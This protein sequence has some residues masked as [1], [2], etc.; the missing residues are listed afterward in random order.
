[1]TPSDVTLTAM[2]AAEN[3]QDIYGPFDSDS[4]LMDALDA[5]ASLISSFLF[6]FQT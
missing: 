6:Y 4:S 3:S 2:E 5:Y 1:M